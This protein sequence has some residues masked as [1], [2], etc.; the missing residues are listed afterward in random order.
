MKKTS[1]QA[2]TSCRVAAF[3]LPLACYAPNV[4]A[5][6]PESCR[7]AVSPIGAVSEHVVRW[8]VPDDRRALDAW[9]AAV[10]P[11]VVAPAAASRTD[12]PAG[13]LVVVTWNVHVGAGDLVSF[14]TGLRNGRFTDGL[15]VEHFVLLLQEA[16]RRGGLVP[17]DPQVG[18]HTPRPILPDRPGPP[19]DI[20]DASTA[21]GLSLFYVPSMRNGPPDR[22]DEDRGNA[23]LS[24]EPLADLAA[25]ELPFD[26]Q[27]RV[28]LQATIRGRQTSGEP[29]T[30]RLA[31]AHFEN[32]GAV[33][34]LWILSMV[35]RLKEARLLLREMTTDGNAI[36]GGDLNTWFGFGEPAYQ[37][38]ASA[39]PRQAS[40]E[41]RP[42]FG[43]FLRLDHLLFRIPEAWKTVTTRLETHGSD[44]HPLLA[45]IGIRS[46][47]SASQP[48]E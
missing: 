19:L 42:T 46:A 13:E 37:A 29:W 16:Y 35:S 38:L 27:R 3:V 20:V 39:L 5:A 7:T 32:V 44:H 15:P 22:T 12:S 21:L 45:Q 24:T 34:R 11:A 31:D 26:R 10:G 47:I 4:N 17:S 33:K 23:I 25:I 14:V 8:I 2:R 40:S 1:W 30:V 9:C 18:R 6:P 43:R 48:P 28:A 36:L 41:R